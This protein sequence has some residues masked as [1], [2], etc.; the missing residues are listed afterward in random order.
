MVPDDAETATAAGYLRRD[1]FHPGWLTQSWDKMLAVATPP[2]FGY[3]FSST[4]SPLWTDPGRK[5][6]S[7]LDRWSSDLFDGVI[8]STGAELVWQESLSLLGGP[9]AGWPGNWWV[10]S[11]SPGGPRVPVGDFL[12]G[13][14]GPPHPPD[15]SPRRCS[16]TPRS[17]GRV[18]GWPPT[19]GTARAWDWESSARQPNSVMLWCPIRFAPDRSPLLRNGRPRRAALP[20]RVH[21]RCSSRPPARPTSSGPRTSERDSSS[22]MTSGNDGNLDVLIRWSRE[23]ADRG[24]TVPDPARL[25][26]ISRSPADWWRAGTDPVEL[27]WRPTVD[28]LLLQVRLG[29]VAA[30]AVEF[31]PDALRTPP[32][33]PPA[34]AFPAEVL[35][36]E[37]EPEP[38]VVD[39]ETLIFQALIDWRSA[40]IAAGVDGAE[41]IKDI[42]LRNLVKY[43]QTGE[44][45]I[46]VKL[47]GQAKGLAGEI[48]AV[49]A[50]FGEPEPD[51]PTAPRTSPVPAISR[52]PE[53][54]P[55]QTRPAPSEPRT[56]GGVLNRHTPT[57]A[58]TTI[59]R[60]TSNR[61]GSLSPRTPT[62][63][64]CRGIRGPRGPVRWSCTGWCRRTGPVPLRRRSTGPR[65]ASSWPRRHRHPWPTAGS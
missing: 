1:L 59:P 7:G 32:G 53:P 25:V 55:A 16:P 41:A 52:P 45:V 40:Q 34:Q 6:G 38:R 12:A 39:R 10:V 3:E 64:H 47:P 9:M 14:T 4:A 48:A 54:V 33:V 37:P 22:D 58:T 29:V 50:R 43:N 35:P 19:S 49:F 57:S 65:P 42:T 2:Q 28:H 17:P 24:L 31:L 11:R 15:R 36:S 44:D 8:T 30:A 18:R 46:R 23:A 21:H 27:A 51:T 56:Q 13:S 61:A 20:I 62:V 63:L 5:T 26:E 60:P